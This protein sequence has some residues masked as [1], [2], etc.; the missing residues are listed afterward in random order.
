MRVG[1]GCLAS[2][3]KEVGFMKFLIWKEWREGFWKLLFCGGASVLFVG[4]LFRLRI[5]QDESNCILISFVQ[6][7]AVPVVYSLDIFSGEMSNRTIHL[8]FKIPVRRWMIF[9]SKY[10]VSVVGIVLVFLVTSLAM[11]FMGGGREVEAG[12][13]IGVNFHFGAAAVVLFTWSCVAG[14][15]S[16]SEAGALGAMFAVFVVWGIIFFCAKICEVRWAVHFAPYSLM[17]VFGGVSAG[18]FVVQSFVLAAGLGVGCLRYVKMRR[19]L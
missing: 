9:L 6:M 17:D 14:C 1:K 15:R 5:I 3:I 12:R 8:L 10:V 13:L 16:E 19:H 7:F 11:E 2:L 18:T 4:L